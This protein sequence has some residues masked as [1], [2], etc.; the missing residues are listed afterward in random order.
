MLCV[1]LQ[2]EVEPSSKVPDKQ[3]PVDVHEV[4]VL[5]TPVNTIPAV[6]RIRNGPVLVEDSPIHGTPQ[7]KQ[8]ES[9]END[10]CVNDRVFNSSDDSLVC[11][12][13]SVSEAKTIASGTPRGPVAP[14][15]DTKRTLSNE[16][17]QYSPGLP[18]LTEDKENM[19]ILIKSPVHRTHMSDTPTSHRSVGGTPSAKLSLKK[20]RRS[21]CHNMTPY[22][23]EDDRDFMGGGDIDVVREELVF[24]P[25]VDNERVINT[26]ESAG[27][28]PEGDNECEINNK[29]PV[30]VS[31]SDTILSTMDDTAYLEFKADVRHNST[32]IVPSAR[33]PARLPVDDDEDDLS[34]SNS[35]ERTNRYVESQLC[36]C[37]HAV[38]V[39]L[40]DSLNVSTYINTKRP[41]ATW[42][43]KN[44]NLRTQLHVHKPNIMH[45]IRI[46]PFKCTVIFTLLKRGILLAPAAASA[47][48]SISVLICSSHTF[49]P[50]APS[51]IKR[52]VPIPGTTW[53]SNVWTATRP[54]HFELDLGE[55]KFP[56][57]H[58]HSQHICNFTGYII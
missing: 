28:S 7:L 27:V 55:C 13:D 39:F 56:Y 20:K 37:Y 48:V 15:G 57:Q 52:G 12:S 36:S 30:G 18:D 42:A 47:L 45:E 14:I 44:K 16:M 26:E 53:T 9:D 25:K 10:E 19:G 58:V 11:I 43:H 17:E 54:G 32:T 38:S 8:V 51:F 6:A 29:A 24:S 41:Q 34:S 23:P 2:G 49:A 40:V 21:V 22:R 35:S 31:P 50:G 46:P 5:D 1:I 33:V 3:I 4:I